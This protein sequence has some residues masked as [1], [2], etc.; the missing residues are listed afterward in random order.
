[1]WNIIKQIFLFRMAQNSTRGVARMVG[2]GRLGVIL[3]IIG[4]IRAVRRQ[5]HA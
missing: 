2:L 5:R 1:M 4:G 3:G